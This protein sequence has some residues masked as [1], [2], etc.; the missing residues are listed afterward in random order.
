MFVEGN[1]KL[2]LCDGIPF[3]LVREGGVPEVCFL[4]TGK[5]GSYDDLKIRS[6]VRKDCLEIKGNSQTVCAICSGNQQLVPLIYTLLI[7]Q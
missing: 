6:V 2:A 7:F 3:G 4:E 5:D 1:G